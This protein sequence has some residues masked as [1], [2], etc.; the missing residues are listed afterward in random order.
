MEEIPNIRHLRVFME[1]AHCRSVSGGAV[2]VHL[3]QPAVTQ[4]IGKLESELGTPLFQRRTDG[5]FLTEIGAQFLLRVER[6]LMHLETGAREVVRIGNRA[7]HG[8]ASKGAGR[9]DHLLTATQLRALVALSESENFSLAAR[10]V[11]VSQPS[12]HRAARNLESIAGVTLFNATPEGIVL[13]AAA[14]SMAQNTR[15]ALAELRQGQ[16]E[17][18]AW[19]GQDSS[20]IMVGSLPLARTSI[21]P[22]AVH[23]LVSER[24]GVQVQVIDGIYGELLNRLRHGTLDFLIGALRFPAPADDVTQE[25]LFDDPLAIVARVGH[26]LAGKKT[27]TLG[28]TLD[29]PWIAPPRTTPAGSYLYETL[30]IHEQ[31]QTPVRVVSSSLVFL[32]GLMTIG[33]YIT[34]ISTHQIRHELESGLLTTLNVSLVNSDRSIG[35]TFRKGWHPTPSQARFLEYVRDVATSGSRAAPGQIDLHSYA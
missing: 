19:L 4:A 17:V 31:P 2:R 8:G 21:V 3:S 29:Y 35:L 23:R 18:A 22:Q 25:L 13:T 5:M 27:V 9:F 11:G 32:R 12:I 7:A 10:Q 33:D 1:V 6:A 26:P 14:R 30:R 15:L 28:E 16:D 20:R 24:E 34:I